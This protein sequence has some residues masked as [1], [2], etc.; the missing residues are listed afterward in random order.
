LRPPQASARPAPLLVNPEDYAEPV[1]A[2]QLGLNLLLVEDNSV[3]LLVAQRLLQ[4]L[5]CTVTT[6]TDGEQALQLL[7]TQSFDLVLMDVQMP[8]MDG[9]AATTHIRA[10]QQPWADIPIIALTA[11]AMPES[12]QYYLSHGM[13]GYITKP[14]NKETL[15]GEINRHVIR[16]QFKRNL[17]RTT[18]T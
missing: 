9:L 1:E 6:A 15:L 16:E 10:S 8:V 7:Q 11:D 12:K 18:P 4:V 3:N 13:N 17:T 2:Q 14:I 5:G